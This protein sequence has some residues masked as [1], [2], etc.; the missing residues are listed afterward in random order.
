MKEDAE[1]SIIDERK[2]RFMVGGV[3]NFALYVMGEMAQRI[4]GMS[5]AI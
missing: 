5:H 3:P 2:F 1:L 4:R